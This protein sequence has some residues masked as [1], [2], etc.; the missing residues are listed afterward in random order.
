M[1]TQTTPASLASP[2]RSLGLAQGDL[3]RKQRLL[4]TLL[5]GLAGPSSFFALVMAVLWAVAGTPVGGFLAIAGNDVRWIIR[6]YT[7]GTITIAPWTWIC[8]VI[9]WNP[10]HDVELVVGEF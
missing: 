2:Y 1:E 9:N 7:A 6:D 3:A 10:C 5:V 8:T 4:R